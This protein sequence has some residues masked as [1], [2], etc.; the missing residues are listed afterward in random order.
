MGTLLLTTV[1]TCNQL[2][3]IAK[4]VI[5]TEMLN[6]KQKTEIMQEFQKAIPSCPLIIK[7][8]DPKRTSGT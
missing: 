8:N 6:S 1:L 7:P 3:L 2:L 4:R 5:N